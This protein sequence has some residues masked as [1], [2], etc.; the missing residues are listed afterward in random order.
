MARNDDSALVD[1]FAR[2]VAAALAAELGED[3]ALSRL[4]AAL[5]DTEAD[6]KP[7]YEDVI[8]ALRQSRK[9]RAR[10]ARDEQAAE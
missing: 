4:T 3:A 2:S 7:I 6:L 9:A 8:A 5:P 10:K 1:R